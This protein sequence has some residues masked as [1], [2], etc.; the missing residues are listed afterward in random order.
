[1][2]VMPCRRRGFTLL[3][4]TLVA[5]LMAVLVLVISAAW[6]GVGNLFFNRL[7]RSRRTPGRRS[8]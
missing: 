5:G 1:M 3:E 8:T 4:V 2:I 7:D 6:A